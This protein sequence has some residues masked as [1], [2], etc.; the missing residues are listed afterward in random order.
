MLT[1]NRTFKCLLAV[2]AV[3]LVDF[4]T[5]ATA[6][7]ESMN[8]VEQSIKILE[9][10]DGDVLNHNDGAETAE[11]LT[12][13]VRGV[14]P[15]GVAVL[16]NGV[17]AERE[18]DRFTCSVPVSVRHS[19]IVAQAGDAKDSIEVW[20]DKASRKRYRFSVDDNIQFLKDLGTAPEKYPSL[21]DHWYLAFWRE[22]HEKYGA[23][24]HLNI[25]YQTDD[26]D[27]S[28]MPDIWK[29][30]WQAN[31]GWLHLSFHAL[32]DKPDRPY[33][34]AKYAQVAHDYDL[35]CGHIRRFAG[36]DVLTTTT[37]THWAQVPKDGVLALRDRGIAQLVGLFGTSHGVTTACYYLT[38]EQSARCDERPAWYDR[39]A[40]IFFVPCAMVVNSYAV[41]KIK[42]LLDAR[43]ESP[44]RAEL[45]ELLIHEQY[46]REDLDLYQPT[47]MDK[48]RAALDWATSNG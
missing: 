48:V 12:V 20:W 42:P 4:V 36:T 15:A 3:V 9:P 30:E 37:T 34:N 16:V 26:F 29:D 25:Y 28:Q 6:L 35:V 41:E 19:S 21:F 38:P 43:A 47:V 45:L 17:Q 1:H 24:I 2:M 10:C 5:G 31:A 23:K 18:G 13:A 32:Q 7:G 40:G 44:H 46:F 11:S 8:N 22:M 14:A 27:L 33:R 39:D